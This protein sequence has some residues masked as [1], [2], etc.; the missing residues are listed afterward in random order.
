MLKWC[1]NRADQSRNVKLMKEMAG[2]TTKNVVYKSLRP[3]QILGSEKMVTCVIE[4]L[5]E[6]Y[7]NPFSVSLDEN[8]YNLSS[9][10]PVEDELANE[11]LCTEQKGSEI[12]GCLANEILLA[13]GTKNFHDPLPRN[14]VYS[15]KS[16]SKNILI[17][18][19]QISKIFHT[20]IFQLCTKIKL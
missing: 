20:L 4:V 11:I 12:Y 8:L 18:K 14:R 13:G 19:K 6:E 9:G 7:L 2:A 15:F 17:K 10:V 1:L 16:T 3:S 5:S